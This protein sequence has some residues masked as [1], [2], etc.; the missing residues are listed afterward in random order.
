MIMNG[1]RWDDVGWV[2]ER[3][4]LPRE[5]PMFNVAMDRYLNWSKST[6][7]A[8]THATTVHNA[9]PLRKEAVAILANGLRKCSEAR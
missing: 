5:D 2:D 3:V 9:K 6:H 7:E 4:K 1:K 8:C